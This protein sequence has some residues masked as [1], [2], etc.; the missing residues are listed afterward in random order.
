M[1][2]LAIAMVLLA[3]TSARAQ[4]QPA[5]KSWYGYEILALDVPVGFISSRVPDA[6]F[7][8]PLTGPMV[9][10]A[11]GQPGRALGSLALRGGL[12]LLGAFG[13]LATA[14]CGGNSE[15]LCGLGQFLVGGLAGFALAEI[16]D[17]AV[18]AWK[19]GADE[20]RPPTRAHKSFEIAPSVAA[21]ANGAMGFGVVG[22][23]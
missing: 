14:H 20:S 17:V 23:F 3:A 4:E 2:W 13:L 22:R 18:L 5:P 11:N 8:M 21:S 15:E 1:R 12:P 6:L 10:L 7:A 9:H 16:I 19:D